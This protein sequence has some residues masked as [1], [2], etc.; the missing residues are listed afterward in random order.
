MSFHRIIIF[1][2]LFYLAA[3]SNGLELS[4]DRAESDGFEVLRT[5]IR[6]QN[7]ANVPPIVNGNLSAASKGLRQ[8]SNS[9]SYFS[10]RSLRNAIRKSCPSEFRE[11]VFRELFHERLSVS[12][13]PLERPD[14]VYFKKDVFSFFVYS[15]LDQIDDCFNKVAEYC[16][17][18]GVRKEKDRFLSFVVDKDINVDLYKRL[19]IRTLFNACPVKL[20]GSLNIF[21]KMSTNDFKGILGPVTSVEVEIDSFVAIDHLLFPNVVDLSVD[22]FLGPALSLRDSV[23]KAFNLDKMESLKFNPQ[24][25]LTSNDVI[26]DMADIVKSCKN[27]ESLELM[28]V[29]SNSLAPVISVAPSG[30]K[31]FC[32]DKLDILSDEVY[33]LNA[34][35]ERSSNSMETL[36]LTYETSGEFFP[37]LPK[38]LTNL[39]LL[40]FYGDAHQSLH[41]QLKN[42]H[43]LK[44]LVSSVSLSNSDFYS[45]IPSS[46]HMLHLADSGGSKYLSN[47]WHLLP[48]VEILVLEDFRSNNQ[49]SVLARIMTSFNIKKIILRNC[50]IQD[51]DFGKSHTSTVET[52]VLESNEV[53]FLDDNQC[54]S[55]Q[56]SISGMKNL[57]NFAILKAGFYDESNLFK[58][59]IAKVNETSSVKVLDMFHANKDA[60]RNLIRKDLLEKE[61]SQT[62]FNRRDMTII[63]H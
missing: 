4:G 50:E 45:N 56:N 51:Y 7:H 43:G 20:K 46:V 24:S 22:F 2:F 36:A 11:K 25:F 37:E 33:A 57:K 32:W 27:L 38:T 58:Q 23:T 1:A 42:M 34:L 16:A 44:E 19:S 5:V 18:G 6:T 14:V 54:M 29:H 55:L 39:T 31:K 59:L 53:M 13:W 17:A 10:M 40:P 28:V 21:N 30:L 48:H 3:V 62:W 9:A 49:E 12:Y 15:T 60:T 8:E 26:Y 52:L 35:F 61:L 63:G 47:V 41:L